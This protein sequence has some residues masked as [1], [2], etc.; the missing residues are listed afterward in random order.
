M[1]REHLIY[2]GNIIYDVYDVRIIIFNFRTSLLNIHADMLT[3][4]AQ[5]HGTRVAVTRVKRYESC[6]KQ[7]NFRSSFTRLLF[8]LTS[9]IIYY[10]K[11]VTYNKD[12]QKTNNTTQ[13]V[14]PVHYVSVRQKKI[15]YVCK[16]YSAHRS[17]TIE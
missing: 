4:H 6:V 17:V 12:V 2:T 9:L 15:K 1:C 8:S 16:V 14:Q 3:Q 11:I 13:T 5:P 10:N 7:T